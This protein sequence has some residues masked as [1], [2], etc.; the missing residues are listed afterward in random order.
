MI[1]QDNVI[2]GSGYIMEVDSSLFIPTLPKLIAKNIV[3]NH[4]LYIIIY[5]VIIYII[6]LVCHVVLQDHVIKGSFD[7]MGRSPS[8]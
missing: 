4:F 1:L 7:F 8:R 3:H 6:I 2:K 5:T